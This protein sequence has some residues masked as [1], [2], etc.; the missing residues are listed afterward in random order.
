[1]AYPNNHPVSEAYLY[2]YSPSVGASAVAARQASPVRGKII[3]VWSVL[4]GAIT[5]ADATVAVAI[6]GTA[7]TG[8]S[9][10]ITQSGSAAGDYDEAFP[11]GANDVNEGD[12][13]S[14]TPSGASGAS[15]AGFFGAI[16]ERQ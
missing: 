12:V 16:I 2:T 15:I 1:M 8:G 5:T 10:T 4:N 11:S 6:N 9:I 13:I 3:K 7:V 14:F